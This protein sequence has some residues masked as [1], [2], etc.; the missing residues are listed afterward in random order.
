MEPPRPCV[1]RVMVTAKK[2]IAI[3]DDDVGILTG[4]ARLLTAHGFSAQKFVSAEAF[5][6]SGSVATVAQGPPNASIIWL[7]PKRGRRRLEATAATLRSPSRTAPSP[8]VSAR[9][10]TPLPR[11]AANVL[12]RWSTLCRVGNAAYRRMARFRCATIWIQPEIFDQT[13][14]SVSVPVLSRN[15]KQLSG[16]RRWSLQRLLAQPIGP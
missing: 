9:R 1:L 11:V 15:R 7:P 4:L 2:I 8:G 12:P 14:A 13:H 3:V 5:L 6:D 10:R 16:R